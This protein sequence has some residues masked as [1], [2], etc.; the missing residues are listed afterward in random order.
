LKVIY[1][2]V[3]G[4]LQ[5]FTG[6]SEF[7][8]HSQRK[9]VYTRQH[10]GAVGQTL[11]PERLLML[12]RVVLIS[13]VLVCLISNTACNRGGQRKE[14]DNVSLDQ[15]VTSDKKPKD[16]IFI[17]FQNNWKKF[18]SPSTQLALPVISPKKEEQP[19]VV[20]QPIITSDCVFSQDAGGFVPQVTIIWVETVQAPPNIA[21][22]R[23]VQQPLPSPLPSQQPQQ[24]LDLSKTRFDLAVHFDGFDKN[25]FTSA[26]AADKDKRF[27]L[28]S[29]SAFIS[30][31]DALLLTGPSLFPRVM[32]FKAEMVRDRDSNREVPRNTLVVRDLSQGLAYTLRLST[33]GQNQWNE[34]KRV[35]F[36][37]PNCPQDF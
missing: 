25:Q 3:L 21:L 31:S 12:F 2:S 27:N 33:L 6:L 26:L 29:N 36:T 9:Q 32:D 17:D 14:G 13:L 28:P 34:A 18:V 5:D 11:V 4:R 10:K 35:V 30:N 22:A 15:D 7:K 16:P 37:T 20:W 1:H 19:Q 8:V 24:T 23:Q